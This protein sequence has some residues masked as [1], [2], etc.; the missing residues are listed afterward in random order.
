MT[1]FEFCHHLKGTRRSLKGLAAL[2]IDLSKAYDI[3]EWPFLRE[4][5]LK[6]GFHR[7]WVNMVMKCAGSVTYNVLHNGKGL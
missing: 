6:L 4:M 2:K 7:R 3:I 5:M 1:A